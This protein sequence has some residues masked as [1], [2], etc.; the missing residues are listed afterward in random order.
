MDYCGTQNHRIFVE[1]A[2]CAC[3]FRQYKYSKREILDKIHLINQYNK[4][5]F[6]IPFI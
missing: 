3:P 1:T 5:L 6:Y 2:P 4:W